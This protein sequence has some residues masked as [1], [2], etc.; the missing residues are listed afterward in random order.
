MSHLRENMQYLRAEKGMSQSKLASMLDVSRQAVAKW[1]SDKSFPEMEKLIKICEIFGCSIDELVRGDLASSRNAFQE[2]SPADE[3][4]RAKTM[5]VESSCEALPEA[6]AREEV[7]EP[8]VSTCEWSTYDAHIRRRAYGYALF[9]FFLLGGIATAFLVEAIQAE[10]LGEVSS[11]GPLLMLTFWA[12]SVACVYL[13][14]RREKEFRH[15]YS[16]ILPPALGEKV[17]ST[18]RK[19]RLA[20]SLL[21]AALVVIAPSIIPGLDGGSAYASAAFWMALSVAASLIV[22]YTVQLGS[23]KINNCRKSVRYACE[24]RGEDT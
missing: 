17:A 13:T 7:K 14:R 23:N 21:F 10:C 11:L 6:C 18:N 9:V 8:R 15:L 20:A 1:E 16:K 12:L 22:N 4:L 19:R 5:D 24:S 3:T 2:C